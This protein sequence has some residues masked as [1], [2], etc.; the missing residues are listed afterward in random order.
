[1]AKPVRLVARTTIIY[2]NKKAPVP[3]GSSFEAEQAD[4]DYLL[5]IGAAVSASTPPPAPPPAQPDRAATVTAATD[6]AKVV[7]DGQ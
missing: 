5:D 4:A 3:A 2:D 7:S 1:M 6:G